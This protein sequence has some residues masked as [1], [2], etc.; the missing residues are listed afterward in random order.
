MIRTAIAMTTP[1][2]GWSM[3]GRFLIWATR[4]AR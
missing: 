1:G 3:F 4:N 2:T